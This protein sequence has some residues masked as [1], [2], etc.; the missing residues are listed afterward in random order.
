[1][2]QS[3]HS[4]ATS[5][6]FISGFLPSL[7]S[8]TVLSGH[9][10]LAAGMIQGGCVSTACKTKHPGHRRVWRGRGRNRIGASS[11]LSLSSPDE[12]GDE[13][14]S[15]SASVYSISLPLPLLMYVCVHFYVCVH[16]CSFQSH[17]SRKVGH[18]FVSCL[19]IT[20]WM[21]KAGLARVTYESCLT[22]HNTEGNRDPNK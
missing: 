2:L 6:P 20:V 3:P 5:N 10:A 14:S 22:Q 17:H 15:Q 12:T 7:R 13:S 21:T 9:S 16:A 8:P 11:R 1:M 19:T 4:T 18:L